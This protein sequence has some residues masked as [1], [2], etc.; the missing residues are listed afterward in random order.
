MALP[1]MIIMAFLHAYYESRC[2][3]RGDIPLV[4][5]RRYV[6]HAAYER[7]R[8]AFDN[9]DK[10]VVMRST[11]PKAG[12]GLFALD[13]FENRFHFSTCCFQLNEQ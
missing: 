3:V 13:D 6:C 2:R 10:V 5:A 12:N 1:Q 9:G 11:I 4:T 7:V 8:L